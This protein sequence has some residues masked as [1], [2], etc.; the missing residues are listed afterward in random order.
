MVDLGSRFGSCNNS[1]CL[2][3]IMPQRSQQRAL[4]GDSLV[5]RSKFMTLVQTHTHTH[6]HMVRFFTTNNKCGFGSNKYN[7][8]VSEIP[9]PLRA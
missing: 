6:A 4:R 5:F 3:N 2:R 9:P 1:A 8:Y 7:F